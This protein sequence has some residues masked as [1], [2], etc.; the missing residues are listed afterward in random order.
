MQTS[1]NERSARQQEHKMVKI[2]IPAGYGVTRYTVR[3]DRGERASVTLEYYNN[4]WVMDN[5]AE[6]MER[7]DIDVDQPLADRKAFA[8]RDVE[9]DVRIDGY[10][11]WGDQVMGFTRIDVNPVGDA[12]IEVDCFTGAGDPNPDVIAK[13]FIARA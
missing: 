12:Y 10:W 4:G 6:P 5:R 11:F 1:K 3:R 13:L 9:F 7:K 2:V 8:A